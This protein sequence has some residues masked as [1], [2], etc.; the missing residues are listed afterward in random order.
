S[1][2]VGGSYNVIQTNA[3][4]SFIGGGYANIM[5]GF[6]GAIGG[7]WGNNEGSYGGIIGGGLFNG[8][9]AT[10]DYSIIVVGYSY[11]VKT[12]TMYAFIGG[13]QYN[14]IQTNAFGA[15][16]A[17]GYQNRIKPGSG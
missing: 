3:S 10:S 8:I 9:E 15:V 7:G 16:I 12:Y 2:I 11:T 14:G 17:G 6:L 4:Y 13:G 5:S 1:T